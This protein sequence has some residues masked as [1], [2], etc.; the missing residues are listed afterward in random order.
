MRII[1]GEEHA[2]ELRSKHTVL[3]LEAF[4]VGPASVTVYCV[5]G[6][7]SIPV[8]EMADLDRLCR[9]HQTFVDAYN[10]KRYSTALEAVEHIRGK[11]SGEI[12]SFYAIICDRIK[13]ENVNTN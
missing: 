11:F 2:N 6:A 12:D 3:E 5:V 9:L 13:E 4:D 8:G 7:E 1:I 10:S